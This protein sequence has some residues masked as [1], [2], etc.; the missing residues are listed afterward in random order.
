MATSV[1]TSRWS[2]SRC[3]RNCQRSWLARSAMT[4]DTLVDSHV[5]DRSRV[6]DSKRTASCRSEMMASDCHGSR[7][8]GHVLVFCTGVWR[9]QSVVIRGDGRPC[10][11]G[12]P[13]V[14]GSP[15]W[16]VFDMPAC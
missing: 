3:R 9:P 8:H 12:T 5:W 11:L 14:G 10:C 13:Q 4:V 2:M 6:W 1:V 15:S 16:V 7:E